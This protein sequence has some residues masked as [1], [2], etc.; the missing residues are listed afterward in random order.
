MNSSWT[1]LLEI[2][3]GLGQSLDSKVVFRRV[4][5]GL[6]L[7]IS[8]DVGT[9]MLKDGDWLKVVAQRGFKRSIV[10]LELK[11]EIERH[12]RLKKAF[13][14]KAP[15]RFQDPSEPDPFDD[16]VEGADLLTGK[17]HSCMAAPML[18]GQEPIGLIT[19]DSLKEGI[20]QAEQ[21][22]LLWFFGSFAALAIHH[23]R[24][25]GSLEESRRL[26]EE[27]NQNLRTSLTRSN[28]NELIGSS[29]KMKFLRQSIEVIATSLAPV[30]ITG[31]TGCGKEI[32][33]RSIHEKSNRRD[34]PLIYVNCAAI[35]E[36]LA[37][38]ELF[39]HVKGAY[40]GAL[41]ERRGK[42]DLADGAT[43]F[44]DEVGE[45][46]LQI[47]ASLLRVLQEGEIQKVGSDSTK[48][49][50]V[51]I[52]S[53]TNRDLQEMMEN[54]LFRRDLYHRLAV[55][56]IMVPSLGE[57]KEDIEELTCHFLHKLADRLGKRF[58]LSPPL[59]ADL[60]ERSW[61]G[62][63]RELF[64]YLESLATWA[65]ALGH[66]TLLSETN[67][68]LPAVNKS[69]PQ[70]NPEI[71]MDLWLDMGFKEATREFQKQLA[72]TALKH[73]QYNQSQAARLLKLDPGN[74]HRKL[75]ELQKP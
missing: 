43:L 29:Q 74:F 54:G 32:V 66:D 33:A 30:L 50:D 41:G 57:R 11:F 15:I 10:D 5:D 58:S 26:L 17:V 63:V 2:S 37:E 18:L 8:Y 40:T 9:I 27:Q 52:L 20:Y 24:L 53:A 38:S 51:R 60:K 4:L 23:A 67:Q 48:K 12:P 34:K 75:T 49:V 72:E 73:C 22:E 7:L 39:G 56:S 61:L 25:I 46:P 42:F 70:E 13:A 14:A 28:G 16:L 68:P 62:G 36:S 45:L 59:I 69:P 47:Q 55:L 21:E 6:S 64:H 1:A 35:P 71:K 31:P 3:L 19:V 44:L 65:K